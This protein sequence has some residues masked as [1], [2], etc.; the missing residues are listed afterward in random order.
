MLFEVRRKLAQAFREHVKKE[1]INQICR[2]K[3]KKQVCALTDTWA[4]TDRR[5]HTH[6]FP[7]IKKEE[8]R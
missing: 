1:R 2:A 7:G 8:D 3:G 5:T 4:D 6:T